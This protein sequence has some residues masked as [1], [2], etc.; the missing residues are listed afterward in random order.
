MDYRQKILEK[1]AEMFCTYGIRAVT[2]DML[3]ARMSISKRTI[4]EVFNDKEDLL[5]GVL[6]WMLDKQSAIF[7]EYLE[8]SEDVIDAVFKMLDL[9]FE[10]FKRM[11]PA[12]HLDMKRFKRELCDYPE[13]TG[14]LPYFSNN[15]AILRRGIE[16][17]LFRADINVE[18][19]SRLMIEVLKMSGN[20]D[21]LPD[22]NEDYAESVRSFYIIFLRGIST[23]KGLE[24]INKYDA[25]LKNESNR[26]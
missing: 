9:M 21:I 12:F 4:Y 18:V 25:R 14:E 26:Q 1:A 10:H 20:K 13:M 2:M 15:E 3:A 17:G 6:K 8:N 11:S 23:S 16:D 19:T 22:Y 24:L 5:R 7:R